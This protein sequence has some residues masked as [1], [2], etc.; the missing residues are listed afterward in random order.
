MRR[1][2]RLNLI[3]L[4]DSSS[5]DED[6]DDEV[7]NIL[8]HPNA[9]SISTPTPNPTNMSRLSLLPAFPSLHQGGVVV[10]RNLDHLLLA[11]VPRQ[12]TRFLF[13]LGLFNTILCHVLIVGHRLTNEQQR[14]RARNTFSSSFTLNDH[15][16]VNNQIPSFFLTLH[17]QLYGDLMRRLHINDVILDYNYP[18]LFKCIDLMTNERI[19]RRFEKH[20]TGHYEQLP[21]S[22]YAIALEFYLQ[23]DGK[24]TV[25]SR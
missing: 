15:R 18:R 6:N 2:Q 14:Q 1:L 13:F 11:N 10:Y 12:L 3:H 24:K 21:L 5:N 22:E 23:M 9:P 20:P 19:Q 16:Q 7:A 17:Q 8:Q 25:P 4:W